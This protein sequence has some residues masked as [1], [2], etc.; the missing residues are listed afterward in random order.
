MPRACWAP[1]GCG[2][3][4]WLARRAVI[5]GF[6]QSAARTWH[7]SWNEHG[8]RSGLCER[9]VPCGARSALVERSEACPGSLVMRR[10]G[11][12][13]PK[14]APQ[15]RDPFQGP[16]VVPDG[17]S[18]RRSDVSSSAKS[19][20]TPSSRSMP[21]YAAAAT[22]AEGARRSSTAPAPSTSA[23]S[24]R[25]GASAPKRSPTIP[26]PSASGATAPASCTSALHSRPGASVSCTRSSAVPSC[27]PSVGAGSP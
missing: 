12:R 18:V 8:V 16:L 3:G 13:L 10:S 27:E 7:D 25:P 23:T 4:W 24:T 11:V 17:T 5:A 26:Q 1:K 19:G 15:V 22:T 2:R 14:A 21:S 20:S 6:A 9:A